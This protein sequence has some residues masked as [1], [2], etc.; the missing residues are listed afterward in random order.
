[1]CSISDAMDLFCWRA[2]SCRAVINSDSSEIL[3]RCPDKDTDNFFMVIFSPQSGNR[4]WHEMRR[5]IC[6]VYL[7]SNYPT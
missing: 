7:N 6:A 4:T 1:M 3:V 5:R 2:M